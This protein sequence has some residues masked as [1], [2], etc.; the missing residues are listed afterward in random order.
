MD[1]FQ[2]QDLSSA[3]DKLKGL[4]GNGKIMVVC[5]YYGAEEL[6]FAGLKFVRD[7]KGNI[8][9]KDMDYGF[10]Q[11]ARHVTGDMYI[12]R[13]ADIIQKTDAT[14]LWNNRNKTYFFKRRIRGICRFGDNIDQ[15][16]K[17][18]LRAI[19]ED[20]STVLPILHIAAKHNVSEHFVR[21]LKHGI[22]EQVD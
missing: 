12:I 20:L 8:I 7:K 21:N 13:I 17:A 10:M 15:V 22:Q 18:K 19:K 6:W 11:D 9:I 16:S 1:L 3:F 2:Q 14:T 5:H 4:H